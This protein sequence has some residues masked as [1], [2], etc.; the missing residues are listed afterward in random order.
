MRVGVDTVTWIGNT[1]YRPDV[2]T[3]GPQLEALFLKVVKS[4]GGETSLEEVGHWRWEF[5]FIF[6]FLSVDAKW[7]VSFPLSTKPYL[8]AAIVCYDMMETISLG[9]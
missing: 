3:F 8:P 5:L 4:S 7:P 6:C 2:W 1:P 9:L